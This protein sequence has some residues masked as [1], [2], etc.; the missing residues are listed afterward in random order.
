MKKF[1]KII[2]ILASF[3]VLAFVLIL[4]ELTLTFYGPLLIILV[5][6]GILVNAIISGNKPNRRLQ[7]PRLR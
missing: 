7:H 4:F 6:A 1:L 2:G 5:G 3:V